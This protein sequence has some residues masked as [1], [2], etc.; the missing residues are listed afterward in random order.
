MATEIIR[1]NSNIATTWVN[2]GYTLI[3]DNVTQPTAPNTDT[4][5]G[6]LGG[7]NDGSEEDQYGCTAPATPGTLSNATLWI[8]SWVAT[9]SSGPP[10]TARQ[11]RIRLNGSWT[12]YANYSGGYGVDGTP[13]YTPNWSSYS[14]TVSGNPIGSAP[15][16]GF[17]HAAVSELGEEWCVLAAYLV[18]T[19]S[20]STSRALARRR[21]LLTR[22][23]NLG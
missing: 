16:I 6:L 4:S 9:V 8:Y 13:Y 15:A 20:A 11:L 7:K 17:K 2:N 22:F 21:A 12:S 10:Y 3:N 18:L 19:T 1:P 14:W 5:T 23:V